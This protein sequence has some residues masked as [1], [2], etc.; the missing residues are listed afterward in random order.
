MRGVVVPGLGIGRKLG[1]PT[2]NL[3]LSFVSHNTKLSFGVYVARV[4]REDK[5]Y[6]S[7]AVVGARQEHGSP[8]VEVFLLD[9]DGD[10]YGKELTVEVLKKISEL[11]RFNNEEE[12]ARKIEN[13]LRKA[14]AYFV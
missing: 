14:R 2:A 10:L 1:Y 8:L 13:D 5:T 11:E 3:K 12:L 4:A 7:V 9:F 6:N